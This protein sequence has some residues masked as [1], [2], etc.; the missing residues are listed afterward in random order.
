M[1]TK[2]K[3]IPAALDKAL[4]RVARPVFEMMARAWD[5]KPALL[6]VRPEDLETLAKEMRKR[7]R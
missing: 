7:K 5:F 4:D 3:Q 6:S 2:E 1:K